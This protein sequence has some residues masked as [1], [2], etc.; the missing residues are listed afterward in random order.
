MGQGAFSARLWPQA[1]GWIDLERLRKDTPPLSGM[2]WPSPCRGGRCAEPP[3]RAEP[4]GCTLFLPSAS[5]RTTLGGTP[6]RAFSGCSWSDSKLDIQRRSGGGECR[7]MGRS[8]GVQSL[9]E[10]SA[11]GSRGAWLLVDVTDVRFVVTDQ[12]EING[13]MDRKKS[14]SVNFEMPTRERP[15]DLSGRDHDVHAL[16][17]PPFSLEND[18]WPTMPKDG[19]AFFHFAFGFRLTS[20]YA[21][22]GTLLL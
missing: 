8:A 9:L 18:P 6:S 4:P 19:V 10:R 20:H 14:I 5:S 16:C 21:T 2:T 12:G 1:I 3:P 11:G 15:A 17:L 22:S 13:H 7:A